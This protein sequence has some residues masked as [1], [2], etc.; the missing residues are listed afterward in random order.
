MD[1]RQLTSWIVPL[2][3][4]QFDLEDFQLWLSGQ[5][6]H[7]AT[8]DD[9]FVLVIPSAII[10]Y[11]YEPVHAFDEEQLELIN[12]VGRLLSPAFRPVSISDQ[13]FGLDSSCAV[14]QT[15]V[16]V[17][18]GELRIKGNSVRL[19]LGNEVQH[20]QQEAAAPLSCAPPHY[21]V[22]LTMPLLSLISQY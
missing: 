4:H 10:G 8:R 5:D 18:S 16:A 6:V 7:V 22:G 9:K 12:G 20:N 21:I 17:N 3:G 2:V 19:V 13:L 1:K 15:V 14:I 11:S